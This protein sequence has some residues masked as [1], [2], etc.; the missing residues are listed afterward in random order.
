MLTRTSRSLRTAR[1]GYACRPPA[2]S[3]YRH[4]AACTRGPTAAPQ[5]YP[6]RT[7]GVPWA[8]QAHLQWFYFRATA[9]EPGTVQY[10]IANAAAVSFPLAWEGTQVCVSTDRKVWTRVDATTYDEERCAF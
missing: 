4:R 2:C 7:R 10:E 8:P 9:S 1:T 5:E 6:R 3:T